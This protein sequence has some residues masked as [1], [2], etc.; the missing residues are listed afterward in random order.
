MVRPGEASGEALDMLTEAARLLRPLGATK[1]LAS[2]LAHL[3]S[4]YSFN[5]DDVLARQYSEEALAI[6]RSLGDRTGEV[7]SYINLAEFAFLRGETHEAIDYATRALGAARANTVKEVQGTVMTNLANYLLSIDDLE[8]ARAM[9]LEALALHRALGNDDYAVVCLE[10]LALAL[11]L[12]GM[13]DVAARLWGFTDSYFRQTEQVRDR[14]E[15]IR[16][17]RLVRALAASLSSQR[18]SAL[19]AEGSA[20]RREQADA[21]AMT[22]R[23]AASHANIAVADSIN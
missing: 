16:S 8:P 17:D 12:A 13:A 3:G 20:W 19:A 10:H 6:R 18:L 21:A 4:F 14:P 11:A 2:A 15:Q 22:W 23:D 5:G 1:D 7:I 9:A